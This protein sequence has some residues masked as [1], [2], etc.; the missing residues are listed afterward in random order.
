MTKLSENL[1]PRNGDP[2][3]ENGDTRPAQYGT[4]Q[5][6]NVAVSD[7]QVQAAAAL[8]RRYVPE[9]LDR[10]EV[11]AV[12]FAP[13][14]RTPPTHKARTHESVVRLNAADEQQRAAEVGS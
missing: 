12:L 8:V 13:P 5:L 3:R 10:D 2:I 7:E 1:T 11:M 6:G 9:G 4:E 14:Y